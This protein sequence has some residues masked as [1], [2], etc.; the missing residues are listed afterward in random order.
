MW[1]RLNYCT[2]NYCTSN[3]IAAG[4]GA[5]RRSGHWALRPES[6][7]RSIAA[8]YDRSEPIR[9]SNRP[10]RWSPMARW[11]SAQALDTGP[12]PISH[13]GSCVRVPQRRIWRVAPGAAP[14]P[15]A[16]RVAPCRNPGR[17]FVELSLGAAV[18]L[19]LD[20]IAA[21]RPAPADCLVL[22]SSLGAPVERVRTPNVDRSAS[23]S[24][25]STKSRPHV[26]GVP[27]RRSRSPLRAV[28]LTDW[29]NG[30]RN[31]GPRQV[32]DCACPPP[33]APDSGHTEQRPRCTQTALEDD[34]P[35]ELFR[36]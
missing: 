1:C 2:S 6:P 24:D 18:R 31:S 10:G 32:P 33:S 5:A 25:I 15:R 22:R 16:G 27:T 19:G 17:D 12:R 14:T 28:A 20:L 30:A 4:P 29:P 3:H 21:W 9:T 7:N 34:P 11:C 13:L 35:R 26:P 36:R 8:A 23:G